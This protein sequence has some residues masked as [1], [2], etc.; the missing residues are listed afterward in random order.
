LRKILIIP[1]SKSGKTSLEFLEKKSSGLRPVCERSGKRQ[2]WSDKAQIGIMECWNDGI[3]EKR[4]AI[5]LKAHQSS[6]PFFHY[7]TFFGVGYVF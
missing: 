3:L 7:S 6:I 1:D 2:E 4:K 5:C